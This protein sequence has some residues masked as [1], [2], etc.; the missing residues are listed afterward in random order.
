MHSGSNVGQMQG[1]KYSK[2]VSNLTKKDLPA[3]KR[4]N[5][6]V[7]SLFRVFFMWK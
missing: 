6:C 2:V 7:F 3:G 4:T 1:G 5:V